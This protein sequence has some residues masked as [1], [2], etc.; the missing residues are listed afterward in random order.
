MLTCQLIKKASYT[1]RTANYHLYFHSLLIHYIYFNGLPRI[2]SER[3]EHLRRAEFSKND[4]RVIVSKY[5]FYHFQF[6]SKV[7]F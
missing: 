2:N 6:R 4:L 7:N 5:A 1:I 3:P